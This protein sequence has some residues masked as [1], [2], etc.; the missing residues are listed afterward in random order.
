MPGNDQPQTSGRLLKLLSLLQ[1]PR[2]WPGPE[3]ADRLGVSE[4]TVRNDINRLRNLGYPVHAAR[5]RIGGYRLA[6]GTAMPP[7]LLDDEE[8]VAIAVTLSTTAGTVEG[9]EE[10][11]VRA[12]TKLMQ[13]LP[14][15]LAGRV[16][17]VRANTVRVGVP[18]GRRAP[19]V[20][21][22]VLALIAGAARDREIVRFAYADHA[23]VAS[24]RRVEPYRLVNMGRR[25]Y[26]VAWDVDR[27]DW[28][29]FRLDRMS[30]TRSVGHR[31]RVRGLPADDIAAYVA[32]RTRQVQMKTTGQVLVHAPAE[33][34]QQRMGSWIQGSI[35]SLSPELCRVRIGARD[36][37]GLAFWLGALEA[38]FEVE[39]S[40]ELAAAVR[41]LADR[42]A[43]AVA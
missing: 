23:G 39:D 5:G 8:A 15:R 16:E 38:D 10:T 21:G 19:R 24:E 30:E 33:R 9:L 42:Y 36:A 18:K 34:V 22:A 37:D 1:T 4:R 6:A 2:E 3:L 35:E 7:L 14:K 40:P 25:W 27:D 31:F 41:A 29:T 20:D 13:V 12:L 32:S 26:L 28:R 11:S 17:A 43:S